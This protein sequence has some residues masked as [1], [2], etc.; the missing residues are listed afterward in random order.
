M[1]VMFVVGNMMKLSVIQNLELHREQNLKIYRMI[2]NARY[3]E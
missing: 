3:A 1:Y 2:L